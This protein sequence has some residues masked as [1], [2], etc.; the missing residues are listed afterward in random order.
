MLTT[1]RAY[2]IEIP[3]PGAPNAARLA[4]KAALAAAVQ[5]RN[6]ARESIRELYYRSHSLLR[7]LRAHLSGVSARS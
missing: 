5:R 2:E 6:G 4:A 7:A 3:V 1:V